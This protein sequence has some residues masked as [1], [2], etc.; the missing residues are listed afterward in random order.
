MAMQEHKPLLWPSEHYVAALTRLGC[1]MLVTIDKTDLYRSLLLRSWRNFLDHPELPRLRGRRGLPLLGEV[2]R[3][4]RTL[5]ALDSG[6]LRYF[7]I[8]AQSMRSTTPIR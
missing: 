5:A 4:I 6:A 1:T 2:E 8:C 3:C 7:Y